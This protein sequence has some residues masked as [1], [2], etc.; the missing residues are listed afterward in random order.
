M[1]KILDKTIEFLYKNEDD[2]DEEKAEIIRYGIEILLIKVIFF[3][4]AMIISLLMHSFWECLIFTVLFSGIRSYAGGYHAYTRTKCFTLS[5]I[6]YLNIL[7][8]ALQTKIW[9]CRFPLHCDMREYRGSTLCVSGRFRFSFTE[10]PKRSGFTLPHTER[11]KN[12]QSCFSS[13]GRM[14]FTRQRILRK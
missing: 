2:M 13:C 14:I 5:M 8:T 10:S 6:T 9:R 4:A 11:W 1:D 7:L 12:P 3:G